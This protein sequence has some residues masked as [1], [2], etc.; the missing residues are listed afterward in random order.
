M[1]DAQLKLSGF[2]SAD[3]SGSQVA[4]GSSSKEAGPTDDQLVESLR[5]GDPASGEMLIRRHHEPL[6]R[7]LYRLCGSSHSA[8]ELLQQTWLSALEHL[9]QYRRSTEGGVGFKAWLFRIASNKANDLWRARG[10]DR[11][12][13]AQ[14]RLVVDEE[15]PDASHRMS[16]SE[17]QDKLR[18]AIDT[19]PE[20]QKQ[21]VLLRY[22]SEM[23]FC[24]IAEMLGCP[25]N[26]A[27]GRM[28]KAM[29]KLK[30]IMEE[31]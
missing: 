11:A 19:L 25:L 3:T 1:K 15:L 13:Q 9:D 21:I 12:A 10:R 7:F 29:Q 2:G 6:L 4:G 28:H 24:E 5:L 20:T 14:L 8:E 18:R 31:S 22:Y 16:G 17:Q 23:K 27:L 30:K 26:T